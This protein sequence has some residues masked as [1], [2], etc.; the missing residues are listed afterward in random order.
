VTPEIFTL[1]ASFMRALCLGWSVTL[2][3]QSHRNLGPSSHYTG[4]VGERD[5]LD[6][7]NEQKRDGAPREQQQRVAVD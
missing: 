5:S 7:P 4:L 3:L 6:S 1:W 2:G